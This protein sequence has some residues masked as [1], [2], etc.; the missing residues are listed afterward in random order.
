MYRK[1][2]VYHAVNQ[3]H[4]MLNFEPWKLMGQDKEK[5]RWERRCEM[6]K[7]E[8]I[9][10][11]TV[12]YVYVH[13]SYRKSYVY[14]AVNHTY[15][16]LNFEAWNMMGQDKEKARRERRCEML[17][18]DIIPAYTVLYVYVHI[19]YRKSYVYH[20]VNH[21]YILLN[22]EAWNMMGQDK[23]KARRERRCEILK[24]DILPVYTLRTCVSYLDIFICYAIL[25]VYIHMLHRKSHIYHTVN[26]KYIAL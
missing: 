13:I 14:H 1:S 9:P 3:T 24:G 10:A 21:T 4:T 25:Y 26:H 2:Y 12:L 22:F 20:A 15:I 19:S 5:A 18:G 8:I 16:L 23:E 6:L 11:Y 7:G 17:K